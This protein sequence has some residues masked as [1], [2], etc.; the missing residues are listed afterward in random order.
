MPRTLGCAASFYECRAA[1]FC[2]GRLR[3]GAAPNARRHARRWACLVWRDVVHAQLTVRDV[4]QTALAHLQTFIRNCK[5][6]F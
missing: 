2:R 5:L 6:F 1:L 3:A 4:T